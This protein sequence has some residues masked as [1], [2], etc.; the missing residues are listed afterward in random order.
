MIIKNN[1]DNDRDKLLDIE[2][3]CDEMFEQITRNDESL[4]RMIADVQSTVDDINFR[5]IDRVHD[6]K[7]AE[8]RIEDK[9]RNINHMIKV[10]LENAYCTIFCGLPFLSLAAIVYLVASK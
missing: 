10:A 5:V 6:A 1:P 9:L 4:R 7:A 2:E 3:T 8:F